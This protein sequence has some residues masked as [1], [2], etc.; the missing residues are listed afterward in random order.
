MLE[1]RIAADTDDGSRAA[2]RHGVLPNRPD[3]AFDMRHSWSALNRIAKSAVAEETNAAPTTLAELV[4]DWRW[5]TTGDAATHRGA[6]GGVACG[7]LPGMP[8]TTTIPH[9]RTETAWATDG[10]NIQMLTTTRLLHTAPRGPT[11]APPMFL[12]GPKNAFLVSGLCHGRGCWNGR[13]GRRALNVAFHGAIRG[14][15][16]PVPLPRGW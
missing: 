16:I 2:Y 3:G 11:P 1:R 5:R 15:N 7:L 8:A 13:C 6:V 10:L 14:D 4:G 9:R 12:T